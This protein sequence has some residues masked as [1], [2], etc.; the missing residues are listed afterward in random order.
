MKP[1]P[2]LPLLLLTVLA[3]LLRVPTL[4]SQSLWRDEVDI[5]LLS[6]W[7][8]PDLIAG[9]WRIGHNGPLYFLGMRVWRIVLGDFEFSLRYPSAM[10]GVLAVPL[11]YILARRLGFSQ[12]A[13]VITAALM[14]TSPYLIWYGQEAKMYALLVVLVLLAFLTHLRALR[15]GRPR[16]W[17]A[18]V[19]ITSL[20]FYIHILSPLML[21]VYTA[22]A[23][24]HNA[25][26]RK[27]WRGWLISMACLTLPY[28][29]LGLWQGQLLLE[30]FNSGHGF[31]P[32]DEQVWLLI[33]FYSHGL[34]DS[35]GP[36]SITLVLF[37]WLCGVFLPQQQ[38]SAWILALWVI[39]P[40]LLVYA[41]SLRVPVFEDRYMIYITPAFYLLVAVGLI[42]LRQRS[43]WL[44]G[45]CLGLMLM[46][47]LI[48]VW[49][50]QRQPHKPDF[51]AASAYL[52]PH[53]PATIMIQTPYLHHTFNY[54]YPHEYEFI[55]GL[56][57]NDGRSPERVNA[58]M[59]QL[60]A[61]R[62]QLW[63]VVSEEHLWDTRQLTRQWLNDNAT[64]VNE[65][66][67]VHVSVYH[68][69]F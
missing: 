64:L 30:D 13:G 6:N 10:M 14:A 53:A 47:N 58:D 41:I 2:R 61:E 12:R 19:I 49:Q 23:L 52:R 16:D 54:Y 20:T 1:P 51:R 67:F 4:A 69:Q 29:P 17:T 26:L 68:Y 66:H 3:Y 35:V 8:W 43:R 46:I 39:L 62:D 42:S 25:D 63:L 44:A 5:L 38:R 57:T 33:Q 50:Q 15:T 59:L 28:L 45:I 11:S 56:W 18:F 27:R 34:I 36:L 48:G 31:Y 32:L 60:T 65:A 21:F 55:E 9:L 37:V 40:L 24:I 22:T 7:A